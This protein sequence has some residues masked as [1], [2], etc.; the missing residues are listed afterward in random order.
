MDLGSA[1]AVSVRRRPDA[2][3]VVDGER[4]RTFAQWDAEIR[5]TATRWRL[6][7]GRPTCW[8]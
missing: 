3:A 1:F 5:A 6:S 2:E 4:R 8:A 7:T